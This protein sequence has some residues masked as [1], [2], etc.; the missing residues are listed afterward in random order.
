MRKIEYGMRKAIAECR[1][2]K[3]GNTEVVACTSSN[4]CDVYLHGNHIAHLPARSTQ[5]PRSVAVNVSTLRKYP[6]RTTVSRLRAL[7]ADV[8]VQDE[9]PYYNGKTIIAY[10]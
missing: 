3:S 10:V 2:W 5:D 9:M 6:T 1:D 8:F 7:G 4:T